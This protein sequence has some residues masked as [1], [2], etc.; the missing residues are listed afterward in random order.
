MTNRLPPNKMLC[1]ALYSA[2]LAMQA[3][4]KPLLDPLGLTYSQ[5]LVLSALWVQDDQ[6]VGQIGAAL[7]LE[8]NTLTP[9]LKRLEQAGWILRQRDTEDERQVRIT[10]TTAGHDLAQRATDV[11]RCFLDKTALNLPDAD[12]L[13]NML[14]DLTRALRPND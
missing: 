3:A 6:S 9:L 8:S 7:N 5:Y 4:Y 11:P 10:L 12:A 14:L 1:F 13:R 2:S